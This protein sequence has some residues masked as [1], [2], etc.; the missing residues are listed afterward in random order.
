MGKDPVTQICKGRER[1]TNHTALTPEGKPT[2]KHGKSSFNDSD[3]ERH[4]N[5]II[6]RRN[7]ISAPIK[8]PQLSLAFPFS[9]VL[10]ALQQKINKVGYTAQDAPSMHTFHLRK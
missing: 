2:E 1:H 10:L 8:L 5:G 4:N 9:S 7:Y 3:T 6:L